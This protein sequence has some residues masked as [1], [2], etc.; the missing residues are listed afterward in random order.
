MQRTRAWRRVAFRPWPGSWPARLATT[1]QHRSSIM[2]H[3]TLRTGLRRLATAAA[4]VLVPG[5]LGAQEL[6]AAADLMAA[7]NK[8]IGG[9]AAFANAQ[10]M[11]ST[12]TFSIPGMGM[13]GELEIFTAR[14][15]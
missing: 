7:Y 12:G 13:T 10:G 15:N 4:L 5:A 8:A 14:P 6:P 3:A 1:N 11:H 9:E 2:M